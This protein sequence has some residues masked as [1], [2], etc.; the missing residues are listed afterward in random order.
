M[1]YMRTKYKFTAEGDKAMWHFISVQGGQQADRNVA[2][3]LVTKTKTSFAA[4]KSERSRMGKSSK[5]DKSSRP[6]VIDRCRCRVDPFC[7]LLP[8]VAVGGM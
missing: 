3:K 6:S 2:M 4:M 5:S 7:Q 8:V 1:L